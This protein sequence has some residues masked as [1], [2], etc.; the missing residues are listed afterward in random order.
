MDKRHRQSAC[1]CK[2][3]ALLGLC[4]LLVTNT[5][6]V[7]QQPSADQL[8]RRSYDSSATGERR[9][10]FVYLPRGY[11]DSNDIQWPVLFFLHGA[12]ERGNA[13]EDLDYLLVHGPLMEAW[14]QRRALPFVIVSP[15][16]PVFAMHDHVA[17]R[18][19]EKPQR[20]D[21]GVP[22]RAPRFRSDLSIARTNAAAFP[23]GSYARYDPYPTGGKLPNGWD[24]IDDELLAILDAT[25]RDFRADPDRIYLTGLSYGGFGAF[26][27]AIVHPHRWAAVAP[28]VGA[29]DL[30]GA[31]RLAQARLPIWLFGGG[32]DTVVK[33]HWLY[34]MARALETAGHP[35]LRFT[36]HEDMSHGAWRRVYA[37]EDLYDWFLRHRRSQRP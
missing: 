23:A 36:V 31:E 17:M 28:I 34:A 35:D 19:K 25:L 32:K 21:N 14:I 11:A 18:A 16:L 24:R 3:A 26:H 30:A 2:R 12:G 27:M 8:L 22:P 10:Y 4:W 33:P 15:Q 9:D 20:L 7:G 5:P 37:G 13:R 6:A 1:A 29:G